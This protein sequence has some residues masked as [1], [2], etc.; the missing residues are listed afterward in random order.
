MEQPVIPRWQ[1]G[2]VGMR[3][4]DMAALGTLVLL[5]AFTGP[6]GA[7]QSSP[8]QIE[9]VNVG[10]PA[11]SGDKETG[12]VRPGAWTPIYLK[13]KP[14][15]TGNFAREYRVLIQALDAEDALYT[16]P[17]PLPALI[18]N[19]DH[20]AVGYLR[21]SSS[22]SEIKVVLQ[23]VKDERTVQTYGKVVRDSGRETV[24]PTA[25][26]VLAVGGRIP[27][28]KLALD[29]TRRQQPN[30]L[31]DPRQFPPG[32]N[33]LDP[34]QQPPN[35][36]LD[37]GEDDARRFAFIE[38][39][40]RL[41]DQWFGY[42]GVDVVV[43]GTKNKDFVNALLEDQT[44]R[45]EALLEWVRR[46]GRLVLSVESTQAEVAKLLGKMPLLGCTLKSSLSLTGQGNLQTWIGAD[47]SLKRLGK[48]VDIQPGP[49]THVILRDSNRPVIVQEA[50]GLG[51]VM[52]VGFDLDM[53][54]FTEWKAAECQKFW[55]KLLSAILDR[56]VDK[57]T[58]SALQNNR[59]AEGELQSAL[60]RGLETFD[61]PV[62]HF[63]WVALFI[64]LYIL[65]VGPLDYFVLK[66]VFKRLELTWF[67][68][69]VLVVT[70]SILAY[71]IAYQA[72]GDGLR[73]NKIDL[74]EYDMSGGQ[75]YGR[76][77]FSVFSPRI[78][79]YTLGQEPSQPGWS[80]ASSEDRPFDGTMLT[81]LAIPTETQRVSSHGLFPHPYAYAEDAE[82]V[83]DMPIP[84]WATRTFT[85][86]WHAG[87]DE[88]NPVI[89][90]DVTLSRLGPP[91]LPT[92]T[93][94]NNLPVELQGVTLI[95][96]GRCYTLPIDKKNLAAG[97]DRRSGNLAPGASVTIDNLFDLNQQAPDLQ[98][99][100]SNLETLRPD[101]IFPPGQKNQGPAPPSMDMQNQLFKAMLFR[102]EA[103]RERNNSGLRLLDQTWRVK[104]QVEAASIE[105]KYRS[106]II[107]VA[108]TALASGRDDPLQQNGSPTRLWM[109]ELPGKKQRPPLAG[110][111]TQETY[112]RVY[113]PLSNSRK[114]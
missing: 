1:Q 27:N 4:Q 64:L 17:V 65:I 47:N 22:A 3:K 9:Q 107:L 24:A 57:F 12:R 63:W 10:L 100:I 18:P 51:R 31:L 41:P 97:E 75:V 74:V 59:P 8:P 110:L 5:S 43:L 73:I 109:G 105:P 19:Q 114:P 86:S 33:P 39:L 23:T 68:F 89:K 112:V 37:D 81:T 85:T 14:G 25:L 103:V 61:I 94:T 87:L 50:C 38:S 46:G 88:K 35:L 92:G 21:P 44:H 54:P 70:I 106:E 40:D 34:D 6:A 60:Q 71:V 99:W 113:I 96:Q 82:G 49:Q 95:Y 78:Q 83:R 72:K 28:L 15:K 56:E 93:I 2:I 36:L 80:A 111:L 77:W 42:D 69:P 55:N 26:L 11:G 101:L 16:Y 29:Q 53:P 62:I 66:K 48:S 58:G 32:V 102:S 13:I 108:R 67:T 45:R 98:S 90:A 91:H 76:S 84:V 30:P 20:L 7:Q 104:P 52:L 79:K